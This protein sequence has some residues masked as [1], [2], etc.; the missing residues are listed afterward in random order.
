MIDTS[1]PKDSSLNLSLDPEMLGGSQRHGRG[2]KSCRFFNHEHAVLDIYRCSKHGGMN[3]FSHDDLVLVLSRTQE[4][5]KTEQQASSICCRGLTP[6]F[7]DL[8]LEITAA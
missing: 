5:C 6:C 3:L 2:T 7:D 4:L 8:A 1:G